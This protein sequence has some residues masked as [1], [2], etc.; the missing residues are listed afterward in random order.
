MATALNIATKFT[1]VDK[2]SPTLKKMGK[3]VTSFKNKAV[4]AYSRV[5]RAQRKLGKGMGKMLGKVGQLGLGFSALMIGQVVAQSNIELE[6]SLKSLSAITGVT[7]DAFTEFETQ[8]EKVSKSQKVFTGE[9]A[10]AFEVVGSAQPELLKNAEALAM[11]TDATITLSKASGDELAPSAQYLTGLLNQYS[12]GAE[13]ATRGMNVLAAASVVGDT[14]I[15]QTAEAFKVAGADA[16]LSAISIEELSGSIATLSKF[17]FK[18]AEAGTKLRNIFSKLAAGEVLPKEAQ[19]LLKQAGVNIDLISDK[20]VPYM[21]RMEELSKIS[22]NSAALTKI[23]GTENKAA[24]AVLLNNLDLLEKNIK[25]VTGTAAATDMAAIKSDTLAN[26]WKELVAQFKNSVTTTNSQ[27]KAFGELKKVMVFVGNNMDTIIRVVLVLAGVFVAFKATMFAISA[28]MKIYSVATKVVTAAQWLWN[29]AMSANPIGLIIIG[30]AA[31]IALIIVIIAKYH[32]FGAA[33]TLLSGP[34]IVII[35]LIQSFR[36]NWGMIQKAFKEGGII[37]GIK[38]I[39]ATL[40]D[41]VLMPL[42]QILELIARIPGADKLVGPAIQKMQEFRE[43]LGVNTTTDEQGKPLNADATTTNV[44][45][46]FMQ[47]TQNNGTLNINDKTGTAEVE[48]DNGL[49]INLTKTFGF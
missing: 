36:R 29:V 46:T 30:I 18:G 13:H 24:A 12:L 40:L 25:G 16:N 21:K 33:L 48:E 22:E 34:F 3:A 41:A 35:N 42:Q 23:F 9:T 10:K 39:G 28:A 4:T 17:G 49:N 45:Q 1:A 47:K 7:G 11:V 38:A 26:R 31:L 44:N 37:G 5:E 6:K 27:N 14:K 2:F 32:K 15:S 8:I 19:K 43:K 20:T